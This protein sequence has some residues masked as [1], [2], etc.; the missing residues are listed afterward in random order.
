MSRDRELI[1]ALIGPSTLRILKLFINNEDQKYYLREISKLSKVPPATTYRIL[2]DLVDKHIIAIE[3]IKKLKL[4]YL[5]YENSGFLLNLY[6]DLK[7]TF[8]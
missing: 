5:D 3:S 8:F 4:Y 7:Y 6:Q 2:H 1:E